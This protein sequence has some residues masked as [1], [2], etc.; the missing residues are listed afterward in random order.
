MVTLGPDGLAVRAATIDELLSDRY[1]SAAGEADLGRANDRL[2]QWCSA[3]AAGNHDRFV[4]RLA[5]DGW[6]VDDV[7]ARLAGARAIVQP[8]WAQ[9]A[10][11]I[12][13][14]LTTAP[15]TP[16][17]A[18]S[19][20]PFEHAFL[21]LADEADRRLGMA[22]PA[23]RV[24][25]EE[26]RKTLRS[27]L[28]QDIGTLCA[29]SLYERFE[30]N[31]DYGQFV[32]DLRA[33]GFADLLTAKPVLM[34]LIA[35][36][37]RQ[38]LD[39]SAEFITR[40]ATDFPHAVV[41]ALEVGLS[42]RHHGGRQAI[43]VGFE[44]GIRVVYKPKDMR[45][46]AA[47]HALIDRLNRSAPITLRAARA[48]SRAG[49]GWSEYIAHSGCRG[50]QDVEF[51]F[52]RAGAWLALFHCLAV[53]DMH[54]DNI[55]A[56]AA[57][58]VPVDLETLLQSGD[59]FDEHD[60]ASVARRTVED[61]VLATGLLPSY[62]SAPGGGD[63]L[64]GGLAP[65]HVSAERIEWRAVNTD[66]MHPLRRRSPVPHRNLPHVGGVYAALEHHAGHV[67]DG[68][69]TYAS[70]LSRVP[71]QELFDGFTGLHTRRVVRPTQFYS[72]LLQRLRDDRT[73]RDGV[74]W[75]AQADFVTRLADWSGDD[76]DWQLYRLEREAL[77]RLDI[78]H[79]TVDNSAGIARA[80]A[81]LADLDGDEIARQA[82][83]I[84]QAW[85]AAVARSPE[86]DDTA[87]RVPLGDTP[88]P[89]PAEFMAE[90][91]AAAEEIG[92]NAI[93]RGG[94]AAWVGL[95]SLATSDACRLQVLGPDLYGGSC[96]IALFLAAHA[97]TH[98]SEQSAD[99]AMAAVSQLRERLGSPDADH[100]ARVLGVGG[101]TGLGSI[102]Y[103]FDVMAELLGDTA[104]LDDACRL[105]ALITDDLIGAD[106]HLDV[107]GGCAGAVLA[108]LRLHRDT[109]CRD[110]LSR[111]Q[112]CGEHL[113]A[114]ERIGVTG[115]RTWRGARPELPAEIGLSHGAAGFAYAL[116]ALAAVTGESAFADAALES[117]A[118]LHAHSDE[119]PRSQWCHG[120]TGVGLA[121]LAMT[122][123]GAAATASVTDDVDHALGGAARQWPCHVDTL[124]CG[125]LGA[126]ELYAEA[127]RVLCREELTAAGSRYAGT[128]LRA[129]RITGDFRWN[130]GSRRFN[131]GLFRG[132]AGVG[133][134]CLRQLDATLPNVLIW[135]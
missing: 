120:A 88:T 14:A 87:T 23:A 7:A 37:T 93:R 4:R 60:A 9:D 97:R 121:R 18:G 84:R 57:H 129:K 67:I 74:S 109:G 132:L 6:H 100:L 64:L 91:D 110:V 104:L 33:G 124:C 41:N 38:W 26:A 105:C 25:T 35:T 72:M 128:V 92:R 8:E 5:R 75:S 69:T 81:R 32:S 96:G 12:G 29:P 117:I 42:D 95:A 133:Y 36:L 66:A 86:R 49:Y 13:P 68:Y 125:S 47:F 106:Q 61:S 103:T 15:E 44:S 131:P 130:V 19:G 116:S 31:R 134:T 73:M 77:Q 78:P 16:L 3:C 10:C 85:A 135:E 53:S 126:V 28:V 21:R 65:G 59:R 118:Y 55:L 56:A 11:W 27:S 51:Y 123:F 40:L 1:V 48:T 102:V 50:A 115:Q 62:A 20:A 2:R 46:D 119:D 70:F 39:A 114:T 113:L 99:L 98:R 34:R 89:S 17:D 108:L 58:P 107:V 127:G 82:E 63:N 111:A 94:G 30:A 22:T 45:V 80:R 52:R 83:V 90:A 79:F 76:P 54:Q 24:L 122:R 101:A 43:L 112:R 71:R